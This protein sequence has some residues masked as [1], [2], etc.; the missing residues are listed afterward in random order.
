M[1]FIKRY[2]TLALLSEKHHQVPVVTQEKRHLG[3]ILTFVGWMLLAF[4]TVFFQ[5]ET[6]QPNQIFT[7]SLS[8]LFIEFTIAHSAM[9]V[10]FFL[11]CIIRGVKFLKPKE[12][13]L[14]FVRSITAIISL[15][16]YSLSRVWTNT[17]D[18]SMLYSTDAFWVVIMLRLLGIKI[19]VAALIGILIGLAGV[20]YVYSY[21]IRTLYDLIGGTIGTLSGVTLALITIITCYLVKQDPPI[22]IGLYQSIIGIASSLLLAIIFGT[23][24]GWKFPDYRSTLTM[25][26]S[27]F[28]FA[29]MLFCIW[30]AFFYTE[31]YIIGAISF[32]LP[33]FVEFINWIVTKETVAS[34][35]V[36]GSIIITIGGL[37]VIFDSY[38]ED[39]K[40]IKHYADSRSIDKRKSNH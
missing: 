12:P 37:I 1:K 39:S 9:F 20:I 31:T 19:R 6:L 34:T 14:L 28:F 38:I 23:I 22:R 27:G 18:N 36:T 25:I 3:I 4:Y 8:T 13:R 35:T 10:F 17:V 2:R 5:V 15:W 40:K 30:E 32:F 33:V 21:D 26:F 29:M 16:C 11:F 24:Y 7:S